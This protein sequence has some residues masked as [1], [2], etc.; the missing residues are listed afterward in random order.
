LN[1]VQRTRFSKFLSKHLRHAPEKLGLRLEAGGRVGVD[2]LLAA[3]AQRG[4]SGTRAEREE[5][6][7]RNDKQ[8]FSFDASGTKIRANQGHSVAVDLQLAPV[9]PPS[10]LYHG[11]GHRSEELV[12][13][14]G[15]KKMKRHHVHLSPDVETATRVGARH[16]E[17]VVFAVDAT[18][19][20]EAGHRFYVS[21]NGVWLTD[22]V[23][24][25]YLRK[26]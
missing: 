16:G 14:E 19:M 20:R 6:V 12:L 17:P 3:C 25:E 11:T 23:P 26:V 15:L 18:V 5:V 10:T 4:F 9:T 8:R 7:A 24:A 13:A 2:E 21:A 1:D 22:E